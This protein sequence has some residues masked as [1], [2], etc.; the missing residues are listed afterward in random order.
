[1]IERETHLK[2]FVRN[3]E[4]KEAVKSF[5]LE[6]LQ[7]QNW[8]SDVPLSLNDAEYAQR[9]KSSVK[10]KIMLESAFEDMEKL[11]E[12]PSTKPTINESR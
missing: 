3:L 11:L 2:N 5:I 6:A 8:L 4:Q 1:M 10:A 7:P 12:K 9:V